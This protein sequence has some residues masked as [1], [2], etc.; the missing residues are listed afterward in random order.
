MASIQSLLNP[1]PEPYRALPP[2]PALTSSTTLSSQASRPKKQKLTKDAPIFTRGKI[3]G[4][5]RYPPCEER[6][7]QL[8]KLHREFQIHPMGRI[9]EYPRHI[10]YN[11][12]K[13]SF[14]E[15]T[16]RESFEVFQY[17]FKIPGE[18]KTWTMMWDYNIG[19]VR[20]THLFKCNDYSKTTPGKM[21]NANPGLREICHSITGGALAAQ[22]Y[23]M[24]YAAAK[25]MAATFCWRI[26]HALTPLFGT[27]FPSLCVH[28]R[29][30]ARY[31]RMQIDPK[32]VEEATETAN[33]YRMLELRLTPASL[34]PDSRRTPPRSSPYPTG[35]QRAIQRKYATS[36]SSCDSAPEYPESF[37]LS[38]LSPVRNPFTPVNTPRSVDGPVRVM[39]SGIRA[40]SPHGHGRGLGHQYPHTVSYLKRQAHVPVHIPS[41]HPRIPSPKNSHIAPSISS[42]SVSER[43]QSDESSESESSIYSSPSSQASDSASASVSLSLDSNDDDDYEIGVTK[44]TRS[45]SQKQN[46]RPEPER[47]STRITRAGQFVRELKA[48]H[49]LL[50]LYMQDVTSD[51]DDMPS[52]RVHSEDGGAR[53][54]KRRRASA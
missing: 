37:C 40:Y 18:E 42:M 38:P 28:P 1:A 50:S 27:D 48:A 2:S 7:E 8:T 31:G 26:R 33:R 35:T 41:S 13:K 12:D 53:G 25:A 44:R 43:A 16:G 24:P 22:G 46:P 39:P 51:L 17:T 36:V 6:D 9:A 30:R 32:I 15:Q 5:L 29:D 45:R 23:W 10:P 19:L 34:Q 21:L 54:R 3:R 52:Q 14:Q 47:R 4:E 20:I 11:S 49:A